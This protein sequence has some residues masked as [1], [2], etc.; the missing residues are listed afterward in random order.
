MKLK[1]I[2]L[3][4]VSFLI[5]SCSTLEEAPLIR[6]KSV[7]TKN[8]QTSVLK[9]PAQ[10]RKNQAAGL[11]AQNDPL[12][13][14]KSAAQNSSWQ[15]VMDISESLLKDS[16]RFSHQQIFE[17]YHNREKAFEATEFYYN[18]IAD[19]E[20]LLKI[21]EFS[22]EYT[23]FKQK[24]SDLI[25]NKM[26]KAD[27]LKIIDGDFNDSFKSA[28]YFHLAKISLE[29][30][31]PDLARKYYS[32]SYN[33]LPQSEL[34]LQAKVLLEQLETAKRVE[35]KTIG[36]VLPMT[37]KFSTVSKK[38]LRGIQVG[39]GLSD[40]NYSSFRLAV[41]DSEGN[42]E[43][44]R[45]GVERLVKEDNVIAIIGSVLSKTSAA[46]A[47]KASELGV[48]SITLSQKSGVT[49]T[50]QNVFRNSLTS[51]MQ[52]RHL[53]KTAIE[54]LGIKRFAVLFPNDQYG[55][56]FTNIFWDEVNA[57]GGTITSAQTYSNKETDFRYVV[58]KLLGTYYIED[59]ADEY[60][61]RLKEWSDSQPKKSVRNSP[62]DDLLP[63][64][65]D[66]DALFIPDN[67]KSLGQIAAM[68]SYNGVRGGVKLLGTNLWNVPGLAKRIPNWTK[69]IV[70]VDSFVSND[71]AFQNSSF[72]KEYRNLFS[73]EPGI[74]EI[75]GYDSALMLRQ[76]IINGA[77]SRES[78]SS[79]L[80]GVSEFPASLGKLS[81]STDR[82][83]Q[84]PLVL[85]TIDNNE[86][87]P[88]KR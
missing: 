64:V 84:R 86:I 23:A 81:M 16:V 80:A 22:N 39:L 25:V 54:D 43:S 61:Y 72:V 19:L 82:E 57:R 76:L 11:L 67:T 17:I 75:Q 1:V 38:T 70:F 20:V 63:P 42:P 30:K 44:A 10:N 8:K 29:E 56:E 83:V 48:P 24:G 77:T 2:V 78:L 35:P 79:A 50:S 31:N 13:Q 66:F 68:L 74:F 6:Q 49:E 51:E 14:L 46:V 26:I 58:Q 12:F 7:P 4:L 3:T 27:L 47:A 60:K 73:E 62:P 45:R 9:P 32:K 15:E 53:V 69:D 85:L 41:V 59:R 37:G 65:V 52:V 33:S 40:Y 87:V 34:G 5:N 55:A 21:P 88:F 36:V 71:P 18:S 28:A